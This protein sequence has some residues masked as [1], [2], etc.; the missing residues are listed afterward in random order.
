[1][2]FTSEAD[3]GFF[4]AVFICS[5][6]YRADVAAALDSESEIPEGNAKTSL[7]AL[8]ELAQKDKNLFARLLDM[9]KRFIS[10]LKSHNTNAS[11]VGDL[12][13]LESKL[14]DVYNSA[15]V[16]VK[17]NTAGSGVKYKINLDTDIEEKNI[18]NGSKC[19]DLM[20]KQAKTADNP[21]SLVKR[22]AMF[23]SEIGQVDFVCGK[24]W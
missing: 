10:N 16:E 12:Q 17:E 19:L 9:V 23:R 6:E 14:R 3:R 13:K 5:K 15:E 21:E 7:T 18:D 2:G 4:S 11:V 22:N 24:T 8:E 20:M 1:M